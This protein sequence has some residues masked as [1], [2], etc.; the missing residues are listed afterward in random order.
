MLV[1]EIYQR[2]CHSA[3]CCGD[4]RDQ[5]GPTGILGCLLPVKLPEG[6]T[7]DAGPLEWLRIRN[8]VSNPVCLLLP[9][10]LEIMKVFEKLQPEFRF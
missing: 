5:G 8:V 6:L 1:E 3:V 4:V 9:H 7:W 10:L 2:Q